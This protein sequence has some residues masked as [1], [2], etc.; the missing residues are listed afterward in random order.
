M[1]VGSSRPEG[2]DRLV[3][4]RLDAISTD[5]QRLEDKVEALI[6]D[7]AML[8]LKAGIWGAVAGMVPASAAVVMTGMLT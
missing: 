6:I 3:L 8:K 1:S 2:Y 7:V 4:F 5:L